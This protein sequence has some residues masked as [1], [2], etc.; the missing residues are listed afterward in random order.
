MKHLV[1]ILTLFATTTSF[2]VGQ[3]ETTTADTLEKKV[4][5]RPHILYFEA[6]GRAAYYNFGYGYAF[7]QR[8][9][10]ELNATIGFCYINGSDGAQLS[11]H[12]IGLFYRYGHRFKFEGGF[13]VTPR[14]NWQ[15]FRGPFYDPELG[16]EISTLPHTVGLFPSVGFVWATRNQLFELGA[17]Y[18]PLID[19]GS[20]ENSI[21]YNFSLFFQFRLKRKNKN[22]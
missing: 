19:P 9:K 20:I 18:T 17:R 7:F 13:S 10:H 22:N 16:Y 4:A 1:C 3:E 5:P 21:P 11:F 15:N 6:M 8:G 2:V 12:P 14:I